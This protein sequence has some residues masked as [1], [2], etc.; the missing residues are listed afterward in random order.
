MAPSAHSQRLHDTGKIR[1]AADHAVVRRASPVGPMLCLA[2]GTAQGENHRRC[3]KDE[4]PHDSFQT[5]S[6][7][8]S[9]TLPNGSSGEVQE[10]R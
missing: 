10:C 2:E 4:R 7:V 1:F 6:P 3:E 5:E 9:R 8:Y